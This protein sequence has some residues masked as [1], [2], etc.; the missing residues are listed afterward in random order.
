MCGSLM[1]API[2]DKA[3]HAEGNNEPLPSV[4][5]IFIRFNKQKNFSQFKSS[6]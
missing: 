5:N 4:Y 6:M 3:I 1:L 2:I